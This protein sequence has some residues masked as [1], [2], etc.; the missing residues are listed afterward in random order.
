MHFLSDLLFLYKAQLNEA[1][2]RF[3]QAEKEKEELKE[4]LHLTQ[5]RFKAMWI[6]LES[7]VITW[8]YMKAKNTTWT[9]FGSSYTHFP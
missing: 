4:S 5:V 2:V 7:C 3:Q 8:L 9:L 6:G 1:N